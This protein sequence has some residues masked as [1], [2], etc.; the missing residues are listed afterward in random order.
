MSGSLKRTER[1]FALTEF[2]RG[3]RTGVTA[4][5]LAERFGV[6]VRTIYRDLDSL[7]AAQLPL[8]ADRGPGGGYALARSYTLPPV[9]FTAQEAAVLIR[10]GEW[11]VQS[12]VLPFFDTLTRAVDKLRG[13]LDRSEQRE[14]LRRLDTLVFV[15]VPARAISPGVRRAVEQAWLEGKILQIRYRSRGEAPGP[16]RRVQIVQIVMERSMTLLHARD[17]DKCARRHF[18][19]DRICSARVEG[20][21]PDTPQDDPT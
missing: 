2:L 6:S 7:R 9:N 15:G 14:L 21:Q 4:E 10:S 1:L 8:H 18:R 16:T 19:L 12:R 5:A 17:L 13:A 20:G 3:R 11:L